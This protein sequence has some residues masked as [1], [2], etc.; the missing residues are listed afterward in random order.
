MATK[1]YPLTVDEDRWEKL[2]NTVARNDSLNDELVRRLEM[3]SFSPEFERR[4]DDRG[5]ISLPKEAYADR[6]VVVL[7]IDVD[8]D[9]EALD[10]DD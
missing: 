1:T 6:E 9:Q 2:K 5:R 8:G 7:V 3:A 10:G 4:A